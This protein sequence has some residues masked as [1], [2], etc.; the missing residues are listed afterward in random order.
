MNDRILDELRIL[1][2]SENIVIKYFDRPE[3][4]S[5]AFDII[6]DN[7]AVRCELTY[8]DLGSLPEEFIFK[9]MKEKLLELNTPK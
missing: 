7:N 4:R 2:D 5:L 1:C 3:R 9:M 6:K 8:E